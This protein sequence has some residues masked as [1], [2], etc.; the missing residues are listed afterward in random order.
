MEQYLTVIEQDHQRFY[1]ADIADRLD[2]EWRPLADPPER[3]FA[4]WHKVEPAPGVEAWSSRP[5]VARGRD[6]Q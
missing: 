2:G 5:P 4:G 1:K 6:I 3:P